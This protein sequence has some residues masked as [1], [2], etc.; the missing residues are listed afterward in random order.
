[1]CLANNGFPS[2]WSL[3]WVVDS[4][5]SSRGSWEESRS[6]GVLQLEQHPEDPCRPVGDGG[7]CDLESHTGEHASNIQVR[8]K[9][10]ISGDR[11]QKQCSLPPRGKTFEQKLEEFRLFISDLDQKK[12]K[13]LVLLLLFCHSS[14]SVKHSLKFFF[15][16]SSGIPA[17]PQFVGMALLDDVVLGYCDTKKKTV[18][19]KL[20]WTKEFFKDN[21][22]HLEWYAGQC[23]EIEPNFFKNTID[24]FKQTLNQDGVSV[25]HVL[26]RIS[27]CEWDDETG[28][29]NGF[30][31]YG[32]DGE[33]FL[34]FDL[35]TLTWSALN[36]QAGTIKLSWDADKSR[37][38]SNENYLTEIFPEFLKT[39]L[40]LGKS[41]LQRTERPSVS[42][43]QK[44]PSSPVSCHASGFYPDRA[45]LIWRKDGEELHE[46]V[47]LGEILPNHDGT[48]Q[49][50][51]DLNV[52]SVPPEDWRRYD[53]VFHLSEAAIRTNWV[54]PP[55]FP[56]VAV[57]IGLLLLILFIT[58]LFM[59]RRNNNGE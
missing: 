41:S 36:P 2:D 39:Y 40:V 3:S 35:T 13:T 48:F 23:F 57:V 16:G 15:T 28:E 14:S 44:T 24:H 30:N 27:G 37:I 56:V 12:M 50:S 7:L 46:D 22:E 19:A 5:S 26:Q 32:Y 21:P 33:D 4:S 11:Q 58:G 1:M 8:N 51:A 34:Q 9:L 38:E 53:C 17:L 31:Q 52:S 18:E 42:L 10:Q 49:T 47:E 29:V 59:W 20:D 45:T 54:S 55:E 43:L 6:P 25:S